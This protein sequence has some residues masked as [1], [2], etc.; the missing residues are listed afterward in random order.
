LKYL[1]VPESCGADFLTSFVSVTGQLSFSDLLFFNFFLDFFFLCFLW[2]SFF[3]F[4][5]TGDGDEEDDELR[6]LKQ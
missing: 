5:R 3:F 6:D 4:L 1:T 2:T